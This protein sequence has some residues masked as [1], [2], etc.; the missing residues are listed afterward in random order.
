MGDGDHRA[1]VVPQMAFQPGHGLGVQM[2]GRLVEQQDVR[3]LQQQTAQGH[4]PPLA[5][6]EDRDLGLAGGATQGIHGQLQAAVQIPRAQMVQAFLD[7]ALTL[8]QGV[9]LVVSQLFAKAHVDLIELGQGIH[10]LLHALFH[11]LAHALAL[12]QGR[13]LLQIAHGEAGAE[14]GLA[15]VVG[16]HPGHDA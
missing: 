16:L 8:D 4:P 11:H 3:L 2:V 5:A 7:F 12:V 6:G 1:L 15:D 13:L 10:H 14:D 9:H